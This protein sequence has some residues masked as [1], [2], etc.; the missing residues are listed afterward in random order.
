MVTYAAPLAD[1]R[2][3]LHELFDY[4]GEIATL[5]GHGEATRDLVDTVLEA[6]ARF[7][8]NELLPLNLSGDEAGCVLENGVVRTPAGFAQAYRAFIEGGWTGLDCDP[9]YG[10]QGL[11]MTVQAVMAEMICS[12]NLSFGTYPGLSHGVYNALMRHGSEA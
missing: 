3:V 1:I 5:P 10:G 4:A 2:F 9:A 8:E 7:C 12:T 6:G 11:P